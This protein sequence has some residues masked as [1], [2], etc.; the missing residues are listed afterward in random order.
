MASCYPSPFHD[1]R[2]VFDFF[3]DTQH[4]NT[5]YMSMDLVF[6]LKWVK[7]VNGWVLYSY[8]FRLSAL[9][10]KQRSNWNVN[11]HPNQFWWTNN[12]GASKA[13][14]KNF[15]VINFLLITLTLTSCIDI[16]CSNRQNNNCL[17][18]WK[19]RQI[20]ALNFLMYLIVD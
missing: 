17:C 19:D 10:S 13:Q 6:V 4:L 9:M 20:L 1:F 18:Q 16:F 14:T 5:L 7:S 8:I 11:I 12:E 3:I 15:R 2:Y